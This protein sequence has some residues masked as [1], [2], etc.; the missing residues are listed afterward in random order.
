MPESIW[1]VLPIFK[2]TKATPC[3]WLFSFLGHGMQCLTRTGQ[4]DSE[5]DGGIFNAGVNLGSPTNIQNDKS[6]PLW[7]A[8]FVFGSWHAMPD[9][10]WAVRLGERRRHF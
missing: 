1:V 3:G 10:N 8:F 9:P 2:T 5:S 7:V 6:Y 4:F